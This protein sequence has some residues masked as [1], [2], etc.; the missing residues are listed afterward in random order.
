MNEQ[1]R[2][3]EEIVSSVKA[4]EKPLR[5]ALQTYEALNKVV[6]EREIVLAAL[7]AA[8]SPLLNAREALQGATTGTK[9]IAVHQIEQAVAKAKEVQ[10]KLDAIAPIR[11]ALTAIEHI[12][13]VFTK[14]LNG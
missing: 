9:Q 11:E 1:D 12:H 6:Q 5:D 14:R 7:A 2:Q 8:N 3:L 13:A 4:C 10:A